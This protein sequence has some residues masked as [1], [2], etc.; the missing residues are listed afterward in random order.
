M[1][2]N[3][4][5]RRVS[6][7]SAVCAALVLSAAPAAAAPDLEITA[8]SVQGTP[9]EGS[10]NTISMTVRNS[11]DEFTNV[12]GIKV[13]LATYTQG[14]P[15]LNRAE[16]ND[17]MISPI[18]P[19][20]QTT[21]NVQNVEFKAQ[22]GMTVQALVDFDNRVPEANEN[23]NTRVLN[24][25]VSGSCYVTPTPTPRPV[26][27]C[28][29]V[30]TFTQPTGTTA[31]AGG[32]DF[33]VRFANQGKGTCNA[34]KVKLMRFT[35]TSCSGYGSQVGGSGALLA[36]PSLA[37]GQSQELAWR[38]EL[39]PGRYCFKPVYSSPHNDANNFNHHPTK[40]LSVQ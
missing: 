5:Q 36:L 16:K 27:D 30:A 1:R 32:V 3:G 7:L 33:T 18:Q 17:I 14:S 20:Q 31:P 9:R 34:N 6:T 28:D 29:L 37:P 8:M 26:G 35:A 23:N 24:T 11:G 22:G 21:F 4:W 10:C 25:N 39:R 15:N 38:D 2:T 19:G 12:A 40:Q 13:F